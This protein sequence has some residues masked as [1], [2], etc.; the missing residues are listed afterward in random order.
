MR[1]YL[2]LCVVA[3]CG[4][5]MAPVGPGEEIEEPGVECD[6]AALEDQLRELPNV[7]A[8]TSIA[9][10]PDMH[11]P[12]R[13]FQLAFEQP[14]D[15]LAPD[16]T[17]E[18]RLWLAHRGCDRPTVV[19]DWGYALGYIFD[20]ELSTMFSA[21]ALWIE[22]RFQGTSV[23]E[24]EDWDWTALTIENGAHDMHEV[25]AA[26]RQLYGARWVSTGAS[27]GGITAT[28]HRYFFPDDLDGTIAYTAPASRARVDPAYQTFLTS[29]LPAPCAQ[30]MRAYQVAALTTHRDVL[31]DR[32][33]GNVP[34]GSEVYYIESIGSILEWT[35]W[36]G[37]GLEYCDYV[38]G[39]DASDDEFWSFFN[40]YANISEPALDEVRSSSALSYEWL[41]EQGFAQQLG[42][43][44]TPHLTVPPITMEELFRYSFPEVTL[45]P[46]DP[47]VTLA[48]RDWVAHEAEDLLLIYGEYDPWSGGALDAPAQPSSARVFVPGG[49]HLASIAWLEEPAR[50]STL[51]Y[52]E[53]MFGVSAERGT[54]A[55][56]AHAQEG[57]NAML[58]RA[59]RHHL[60]RLIA[61]RAQ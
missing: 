28:Y 2:V 5:P 42:A 60:T 46:H 14:I 24:P 31:M 37:H 56:A 4:D 3:A 8:V 52:A 30:R 9:C 58:E 32:L 10:S 22:H 61:H 40:A 51:A 36:Q 1:R 35:F 6:E 27:K 57:R 25:I 12:A 33:V 44:V 50:S 20:E 47:S 26:F 11:P 17:F 43:H 39:D 48:V 19:A 13:C 41:T 16:A 34:A 49:N 53:T 59:V 38:P 21:N 7:R 45:P 55:R 54:L 23:P 15:H 29:T 18:Q